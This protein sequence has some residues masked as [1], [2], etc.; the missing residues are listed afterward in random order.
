M[1]RYP[2][3]R[4]RDSYDDYVI[5]EAISALFVPLRL[6]IGIAAVPAGIVTVT[7]ARQAWVASTL[8][9]WW[10]ER[11]K[12]GPID[13]WAI[14]I[15]S[16]VEVVTGIVLFVLP[17]FLAMVLLA[18]FHARV[19]TRVALGLGGLR[20]PDRTGY[21]PDFNIVAVVFLP[22]LSRVIFFVSV[23]GAFIVIPTIWVWFLGP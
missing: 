5:R 14:V 7:T 3:E 6:L 11:Q 22:F 23:I 12:S 16:L 1:I 8:G 13:S 19:Q 21:S 17:C 20:G 2:N 18:R 10:S 9:Q 4:H 15:L